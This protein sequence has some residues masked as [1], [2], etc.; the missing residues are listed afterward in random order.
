[1]TSEYVI[2]LDL[3]GTKI[4]S[5]CVDRD[6]NVVDED[7]RETGAE[8]GPD[9]L[10]GRMVE[11]ARSAAGAHKILAVGISTPGPTRTKDGIVTT[12]P[13]LPGWHDVPLAKLISER[14][15]L[16]A[17]IENDVN[18]GALAEHR[19]GAGRGTKHLVMVAPGTGVGGGLVLDGKLYRGAS[20]GAGEVGHMQMDPAGPRCPCGRHGCLEVLASGK[21]LG[22]IA[23]QIAGNEPDGLVAKIAAQEGDEPDARILDLA[24]EQ[25]DESAMTALIRAGTYF[26]AGLTNLI[27]VF[28]PEVIVIGGSL[29]KSALY[30]QTALSQA[31]LQAFPQHAADVRIVEAELG[32]NAPAIGAAIIAWEHLAE[33]RNQGT[34]AP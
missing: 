3:G 19:I 17:W 29:R 33:V 34:R 31:K 26:G 32:D 23:R 30:Y 14:M 28:N 8:D 11:S 12:P 6:L 27:D 1:V 21:A 16:P 25:G 2:G 13:N 22:E 9:A 7:R 10:I 24:A 5:L 15:G 20:G 18:A 4:L